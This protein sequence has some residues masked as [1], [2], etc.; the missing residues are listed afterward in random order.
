MS[1]RMHK[2][3]QQ[4]IFMHA[5]QIIL[6]IL[7]LIRELEHSHPTCYVTLVALLVSKSATSVT[8]QVGWPEVKA[9]KFENATLAPD[10]KR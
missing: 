5:L 3:L 7:G 4:T 6:R 8:Q 1:R 10:F 9:F 2:T